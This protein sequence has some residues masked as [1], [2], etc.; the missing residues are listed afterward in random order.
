MIAWRW[1]LDSG[2][3]AV[4]PAVLK[5][6]RHWKEDPDLDGI[7]DPAALSSLPGEERRLW[8]SLREEAATMLKR[9]QGERP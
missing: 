7:R 9:I 1:A 6:L 8:Q 3:P 4:R 5:G 2:L